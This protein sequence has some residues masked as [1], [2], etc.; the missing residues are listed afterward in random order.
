M[1]LVSVGDCGV[2]DQLFF[3]TS[4]SEL[5]NMCNISHTN[6]KFNPRTRSQPHQQ[7]Q[8]ESECNRSSTPCF[9]I[10]NG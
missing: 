10:Q 4:H 1:C 9:T 7:L 8:P 6:F 2:H 5:T 3:F